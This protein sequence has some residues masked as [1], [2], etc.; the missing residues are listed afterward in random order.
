[1]T[2]FTDIVSALVYFVKEKRLAIYP[3]DE[4][5]GWNECDFQEFLKGKK[6][7]FTVDSDEKVLL[8]QLSNQALD[9]IANGEWH[10]LTDTRSWVEGLKRLRVHVLQIQTHIKPIRLNGRQKLPSYKVN[11]PV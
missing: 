2:D 6:K 8:L 9:D 7:Y 4:I 3:I 11:T 5:I 10:E 1:M